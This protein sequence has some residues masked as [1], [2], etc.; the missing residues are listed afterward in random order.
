MGKIGERG[1]FEAAGGIVWRDGV[2]GP[3]LAVIYRPGL[4]DWCLPKGHLKKGET[5]RQA[6]LREVVEE[7]GCQAAIEE[8]VGCSTYLVQGTPK[9]VLFWNMR[10]Q[11]EGAFKPNKEV[12]KLAW[13]SVAEA[14]KRMIYASEIRLVLE[15][16]A[17]RG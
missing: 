16:A 11:G 3:E 8:Y 9:V 1:V 5:Y 6:A 10:V 4:G 15:G 2:S 17:A 7:T 13:L 14:V 12:D